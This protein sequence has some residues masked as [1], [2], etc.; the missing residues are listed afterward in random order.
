MLL[1]VEKG[2]RDGICHYIHQYAKAN[3]KYMKDFDKNKESL[4]INYWGTNILYGWVMSQNLPVGSLK[5]VE[6]TSQFIKDFIKTFLK[7]MFNTLK[8]YINFAMIYTFCLK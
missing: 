6:S 3:N 1:M 2:I 8:C 4:Y 7:L 5:S